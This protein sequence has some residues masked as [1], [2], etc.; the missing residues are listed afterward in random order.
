V[1]YASK[2]E[3]VFRLRRHREEAAHQEFMAIHGALTEQEDRFHVLQEVLR[4]SADDWVHR[5]E[6][7]GIDIGEMDLYYGYFRRHCAE[8]LE[9]KQTIDA[10]SRSCEAKRRVL[11]E[12]VKEKQVVSAIETRRQGLYVREVNK[13]EQHLLDEVGGRQAKNNRG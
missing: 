2:L 1:G 10:L 6:D 5:Q 13:K 4:A 3:A 11:I 12:A 7:G 8:A 9:R